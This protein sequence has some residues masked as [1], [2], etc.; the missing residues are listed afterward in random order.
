M[1]FRSEAIMAMNR[2]PVTISLSDRMP[3]QDS[4]SPRLDFRGDD[5]SMYVWWK[6]SPTP[7]FL[8]LRA[9]YR[10]RGGAGRCR[11]RLR[12]HQARPR[13]GLRLAP[14][15]EPPGS[16]LSLL[17]TLSS[18]RVNTDVRQ[19]WA[20]SENIFLSTFLEYKNSRK[21]QVAL[22]ILLIG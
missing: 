11:G 5:A 3:E 1:L 17:R 12:A 22:S 16:P 8:G 19:F 20:F 18:F 2:P 7:N 13:V 15:W 21:Q 14:F 9:T 10:R 4:R 6:I